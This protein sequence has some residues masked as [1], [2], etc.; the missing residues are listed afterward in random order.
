MIW[1]EERGDIASSTLQTQ[2]FL[3]ILFLMLFSENESVRIKPTEYQESQGKSRRKT[4][5]G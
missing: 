3:I 1:H 5:E 2:Q 4:W